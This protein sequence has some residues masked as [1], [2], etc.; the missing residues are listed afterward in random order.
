MQQAQEDQRWQRS[1]KRHISV[2]ERALW[3]HRLEVPAR[4]DEL[5]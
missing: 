5:W 1:A 3:M 2:L 4:P